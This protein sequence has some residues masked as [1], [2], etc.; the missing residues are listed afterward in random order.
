[1]T[2]GIRNQMQ[3]VDTGMK[4]ESQGMPELAGKYL[5]FR[6]ASEEYAIEI[7]KVREIIG[8]MDITEVPRLPMY[9]RGV[10]NLR[11]K[12]IPVVDL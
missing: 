2:A 5:T 4:N 7:L 10:I 1:M 8:L 11:G 9:V 3:Y 6:L 12:V